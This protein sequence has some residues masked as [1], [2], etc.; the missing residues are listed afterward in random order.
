MINSIDRLDRFLFYLFN[1]R[2][3]SPFQ[4]AI[5]PL[6]RNQFT[7]APLYLFL[8]IFMVWN[9]KGKGLAWCVF[10]LVAF[11]LGDTISAKLI[12]FEVQ[13]L[14]PCNDP[15]MQAHLRLLVDCGSGFSFPSAHATN[16]FAL[17]MFG[18]VTLR[19][20]WKPVVPVALCWAAVVAY[21]QVYVGVHYPF[22]ILTGALLGT[23]IGWFTGSYFNTRISLD[24]HK[25]WFATRAETPAP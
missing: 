14:R 13:R 4:D 20:Y 3:T 8:L 18:I 6:M 1:N 24:A 12:K 16:H 9:F 15:W 19:Q 21:S 22:D 25:G 23:L 5:M 11:G 17:A 2:L 10:F 7:W